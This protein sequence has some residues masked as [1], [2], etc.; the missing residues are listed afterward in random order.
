LF[1]FTYAEA[2]LHHR[3]FPSDTPGPE[4]DL[5][6]GRH[7]NPE[8]LLFPL[9]HKSQE[10]RKTRII[11]KTAINPARIAVRQLYTQGRGRDFLTTYPPGHPSVFQPNNSGET[12]RSFRREAEPFGIIPESRSP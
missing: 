4:F 5:Y 11:W 12:E 6:E 1:S 2:P 10:Q 8:D 9:I 3:H 7:G